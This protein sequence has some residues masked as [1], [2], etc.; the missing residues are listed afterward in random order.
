M[1]NR[2]WTMGNRFIRLTSTT[3]GN[4]CQLPIALCQ[5]KKACYLKI[6]N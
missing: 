3:F 5:L 2:Q 6:K 1:S 4:F